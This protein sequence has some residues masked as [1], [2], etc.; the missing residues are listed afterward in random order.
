MCAVSRPDAWAPCRAVGM[1]SKSAEGL[2][3]MLTW[4]PPVPYDSSLGSM[5]ATGHS[6]HT[7]I[8]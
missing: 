1:V 4:L 6:N 3:F 8:R 5:P 7:L 2:F